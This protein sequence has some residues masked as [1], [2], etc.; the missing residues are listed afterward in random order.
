[1]K[2][3]WKDTRTHRPS[4]G[5]LTSLPRQYNPL[6]VSVNWLWFLGLLVCLRWAW[7]HADRALVTLLEMFT[8]LLNRVNEGM[9]VWKSSSTNVLETSNFE[10][11]VEYDSSYYVRKGHKTL[12]NI[13]VC[14]SVSIFTW[15]QSKLL[16]DTS[17]ML[18]LTNS[19]AT[20]KSCME[21][22]HWVPLAWH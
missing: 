11:F 1:M 13:Q 4:G 20:S 6:T 22:T 9:E 21:T 5:R 17:Q 3:L 10:K 14:V 15:V 16:K 8:C 18:L 7:G 12:S 2:N 19:W